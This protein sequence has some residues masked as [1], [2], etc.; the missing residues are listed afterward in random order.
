M[1]PLTITEYIIFPLEYLFFFLPLE[2]EV[3]YQVLRSMYLHMN[4]LTATKY[5]IFPFE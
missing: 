5:V 3:F 4:P 1:H 2:F